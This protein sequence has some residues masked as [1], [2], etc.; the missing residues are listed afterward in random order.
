MY[1]NQTIE[2]WQ[3][4][5]NQFYATEGRQKYTLVNSM[6]KGIKVF[7]LPV[8]SLAKFY[9]VN[10]VSGVKE[11]RM[12][13][14]RVVG[15]VSKAPLTVECSKVSLL[16]DY[17]NG[18]KVIMNGTVK[19]VFTQAYKIERLDFTASDY[20]ELIP[21]P[22]EDLSTSPTLDPKADTKKRP[23]S[24]RA[25]ASNKEASQSVPERVVN[26]FGV[27][28][29]T[30]RNLEVI[31]RTNPGIDISDEGVARTIILANNHDDCIPDTL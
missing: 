18:T 17:T 14:D 25:G 15:L 22:K 8:S 11:M 9:H 20:V 30:M 2:F 16:S 19:V 5:V 1:W 27:T 4:F 24:K 29:K 13:L 26:E 3:G 6:D 10:C 28:N 12:T 7:E 31:E 21:R 23:T